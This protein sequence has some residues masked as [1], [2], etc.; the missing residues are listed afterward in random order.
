MNYFVYRF[1]CDPAKP[2]TEILIS[3]LAELDFDSFID[4]ESGTDA[5]V[6][7]DPESAEK[8]Q[9]LIVSLDGTVIYERESI[10]KQNWKEQ[11]ES[12]CLYPSPSPPDS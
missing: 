3:Q 6:P 8:V 1:T 5:Y 12:A 4:N 7:A 2:T 9:E 10:P 11:C